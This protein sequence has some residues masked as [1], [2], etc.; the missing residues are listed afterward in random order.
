M[1]RKQN[2]I[3]KLLDH[4]Y[5]CQGIISCYESNDLIKEM[6]QYRCTN[7]EWIVLLA[8]PDPI[9]RRVANIALG[10]E[11]EKIDSVADLFPKT[12]KV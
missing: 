8:H 1:E 3:E 5:K 7:E 10:N 11:V 2:K 12:C 9:L 6:F 4:I